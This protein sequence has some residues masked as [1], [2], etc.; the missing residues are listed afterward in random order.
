VTDEEIIGRVYELA[1]Q[2]NSPY[3]SGALIGF[4]EKYR[5][6][7]VKAVRPRQVIEHDL[8]TARALRDKWMRTFPHP[9]ASRMWEDNDR[10]IA[11]LAAELRRATP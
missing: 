4:A 3:L 5:S 2:A 11:K 7:G 1:E 10:E 8:A 6:A 9:F